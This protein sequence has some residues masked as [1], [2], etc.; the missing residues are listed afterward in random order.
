MKTGSEVYRDIDRSV[1][2]AQAQLDSV[3]EEIGRLREQREATR[4]EEARLLGEL[5]RIRCAELAADRIAGGLDRADRDALAVL[6]Q[7]KRALGELDQRIAAAERELDELTQQRERTRHAQDGAVAAHAARVERTLQQLA[8]TERYEAQLAR[9]ERTTSQA[10][11]ASDKAKLAEADRDNKRKPY[12]RDK[13]FHYLWKRRYRFPEYRALPVFRAADGW[14]ARLCGYDRAHRDYGML[15]AIPERLRVHADR[16]LAEATT[17]A[18]ALAALERDAL[19]GD[20]SQELAEAAKAAARELGEVEER[21]AAQERSNQELVEQRAQFVAGED[22][23]SRQA[24][25]V[26][27]RQIESED[28]AT[29][30]SDAARTGSPEDDVVAAAVLDLRRRQTDLDQRLETA[31]GDQDRALQALREVQRLRQ[32]FRQSGFD[33]N[34]SVFDADDGILGALGGLARGALMFGD[35]WSIVNRS[36]RFRRLHQRAPSNGAEIALNVLGGLLSTAASALGN[37]SGSF[38]G[39]P[40]SGGGFDWG[41]FGGSSGGGGGFSGGDSGGFTTTDSF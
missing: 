11:H 32:R 36:Q 2:Q 28:V 33:A 20:G 41:G 26:L 18:D 22:P 17:E 27:Q 23:F 38:G 9:V 8:T 16:L 14:V 15:L 4:T 19:A 7:R 6:E 24:R 30:R 3:G 40:P 35:A 37:S 25:A 10:A 34:N 1:R 5:A 13:L 39:S 21:V 31:R 12:E 29:L